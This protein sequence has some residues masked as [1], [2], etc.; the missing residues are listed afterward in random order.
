VGEDRWISVVVDGDEA[1]S[2]L[3]R[4]MGDPVWAARPEFSD[5]AGRLQHI[6]AL[7]DR[8]AGFTKNCDDRE[9]AARLQEHGVAAAP[10]LCV[11]DLLDDP[12]WKARKTFVEVR[13]PLGFDETIY[14]A[15][16]KTSLTE[17][18]VEPG[19]A[20]GQ[21]NQR[22]YRELLGLSEERYQDLIERRVIY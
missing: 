1:W 3:R 17:A 11:G 20:M 8:L 19:G 6:E 14:G 9:L 21:H 12:H 15:Y 4:A 5:L 2:G 18:C 16:V 7:H 13:H 10:V 22:V